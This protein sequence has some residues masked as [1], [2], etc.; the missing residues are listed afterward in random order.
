MD[1]D[2][3]VRP[4]RETN[5]RSGMPTWLQLVLVLATTP[6]GIGAYHMTIGFPAIKGQEDHESR[7][8]FVEHRQD[9]NTAKIET[10]SADLAYLKA[11]AEFQQKTL[12]TIEAQ[13]DAM[14]KMLMELKA[15]QR[16]LAP[17]QPAR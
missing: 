8:T 10:L 13:H 2:A 6:V 1:K 11:A 7:L 16:E 14:M 17:A 5:G 9:I 3:S 4:E 15:G 12:T